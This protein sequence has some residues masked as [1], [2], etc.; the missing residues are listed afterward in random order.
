MKI[1][2]IFKTLSAAALA[3]CIGGSAYAETLKVG[4]NAGYA[5]F[6]FTEGSNVVGFD[7]D[8][9]K[10][11][12]EASGFDVEIVDMPFDNLENALNNG[13]VNIVIAALSI[14]PE[15]SQKMD[16]SESYYASGLSILVR[17]EDQGT[18]AKAEDMQGK[19][20]CAQSG[21]TGAEEAE[22]LS[23]GNVKRFSS[24][25]E[26]F[27]ELQSRRC[28]GVINDRP[29]NLYFLSSKGIKDIVEISDILSAE[30]Y[31]IAVKKGDAATLKRIDDGLKKIKTTGKYVMI[32]RKWFAVGQ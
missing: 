21:S 11:I 29:V 9:I 7:I 24:Q 31:G 32:H 20:L 16:F 30:D 26:A 14:T 6:E 4:T 5:P 3:M 27:M 2:S 25:P 19:V 18:Y 13:T 10:A 28:D 17:Q 12:G 22:R 15:R 8:V 1:K 23:P